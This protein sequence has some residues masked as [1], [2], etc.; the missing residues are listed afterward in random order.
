L[1]RKQAV[2]LL[3]EIFERCTLFDGN[4]LALMPPDSEGLL[5]QG[6]Q[7]HLKVPIDKETQACMEQI[8]E[9]YSCCLHFINRSGEDLAIIYRPKK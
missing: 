7:V 9:K 6:Y 1:N 3:K 5:S 2:V 8:A 4:Y